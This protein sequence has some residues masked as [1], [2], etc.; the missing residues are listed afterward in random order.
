MQFIV[1]WLVLALCSTV[2]NERQDSEKLNH[3]NG[4]KLTR[5]QLKR[6]KTPV[7]RKR[8]NKARKSTFFMSVFPYI[9]LYFG[10]FLTT[11]RHTVGTD[12]FRAWVTCA[13]TVSK[14]ALKKMSRQERRSYDR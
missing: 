7:R 8:G 1:D 13:R 14:S 3:K 4:P 2:Q 12:T 5:G 10:S 6:H 11:D 9:C